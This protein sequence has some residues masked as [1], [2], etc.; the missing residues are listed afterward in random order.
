MYISYNW[1][2]SLIEFPADCNELAAALTNVGLAVEGISAH[3]DDW[4]LD[5]DITSNRPDCLSHLGIAREVAVIYGVPLLLPDEAEAVAV[6]EIPFPAILAPDVIRLDAEDLCYRFTGRI[7]RGVTIGPSPD[8]LVKRLE[9]IGERSINNVADITNFVMHELGQPMHAFDLNRLTEE[10]IVVR[11]ARKGETIITLDGVER[12]LDAEMLAIC[13]AQKPVAVAGI[14]GGLESAISD[15]TTNVFLEV[16]YFKRESIRRTSRRLGLS[17]EA[18][19]RFER[20]VD[21][22]NLKRASNRA[23]ELIVSIAGGVAGDIIDIYPVKPERPVIRVSDLP[24]SVKRLTG[25][26][27][28][29]NTADQILNALGIRINEDGEYIPPSWRY[30]VAIEEDLVEEVVR[31][32]GYDKIGSEIAMGH[33]AGHYRDG[34][35]R[36]RTIR[37]TLVE[38]GCR[39]AITYSFIDTRH[40]ALYDPIPSVAAR[41]ADAGPVTL[42]DAVIEG[43]IRMRPTLLPGLLDAIKLNLNHQRN[44]LKLFEIGTVFAAGRSGD[45]PFERESFAMVFTG[46]EMLAGRAEP[47]RNLDFFDLKGVFEAAMEAIALPHLRFIET[48]ARHLTPGQTAAIWLGSE[49][50]GYIGRISREIADDYKFKKAVYALEIDLAAAL[51]AKCEKT[52]YRPLPR[53]PSIIRDVS[54]LVTPDLTLDRLNRSASHSRPAILRHVDF[55]DVFEGAGVPDGMR[56]MTM[57]FEYRSDERTLTEEDVTAAHEAFIRGI[58]AELGIT[59]RA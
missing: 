35:E 32:F 25:L 36:K 59:R 33:E 26:E 39:E 41:L 55:V 30:D 1:L 8:W 56:S 49:K 45:L 5:I 34:E 13:D 19:Y 18:S 10:R 43:A 37:Q 27:I 21:I 2:K 42:R 47:V 4:V 31:H 3:G 11:R 12:E 28:E 58:E 23:A 57:R 17:T 52:I 29:E 22:E 15:A 50:I 51:A 46:G 44:N 6:D 7:I 9:A 16:A 40:D 24:R 54:F 48:E 14:M 53:F 20:G 38:Y